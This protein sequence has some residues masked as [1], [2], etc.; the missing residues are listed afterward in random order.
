MT[1][2]IHL[3]FRDI[4]DYGTPEGARKRAMHSGGS[5]TKPPSSGGWGG[6]KGIGGGGPTSAEGGFNMTPIQK[7]LHQHWTSPG[8]NGPGAVHKG[9]LG[10]S[11]K[12]PDVQVYQH[13]QHGRV[14]IHPSGTV[15]TGVKSQGGWFHPDKTP[16][17]QTFGRGK[18]A[19]SHLWR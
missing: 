5:T 1:R 9:P 11:N 16:P 14:H 4:Q 6:G 15:K 10:G 13:P 19:R 18:G 3:H 2:H 17:A 8:K 7:S 12:F